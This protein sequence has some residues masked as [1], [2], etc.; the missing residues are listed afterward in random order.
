MTTLTGYARLQGTLIAKPIP[1]DFRDRSVGGYS[2]LDTTTGRALGVV[3]EKDG[4][5]VTAASANAYKMNASDEVPGFLTACLRETFSSREEAATALI[6]QLLSR[7]AP[8]LG[9]APHLDVVPA[10][11]VE[12]YA[13]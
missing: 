1:V 7:Q 9:F 5:F 11:E 4:F 6:S 12:Q 13:M 2:V 3:I 8:A 10:A